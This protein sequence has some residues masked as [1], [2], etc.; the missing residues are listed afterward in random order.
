MLDPDGTFGRIEEVYERRRGD[1]V[2]FAREASVLV[3]GAGLTPREM[4]LAYA[5]IRELAQTLPVKLASSEEVS[6]ATALCSQT[7]QR[8]RAC[9]EYNELI[10]TWPGPIAHEVRQLVRT[11]ERKG[12]DA[13]A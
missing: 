4:G 7:A 12:R 9:T 6:R 10:R 13:P 2:A 1:T 3:G 11:L 8:L 5:R